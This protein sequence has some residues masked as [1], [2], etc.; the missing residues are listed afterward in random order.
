MIYK[1]V[2]LRPTGPHL[3]PTGLDADYRNWGSYFIAKIRTKKLPEAWAEE[4]DASA[5]EWNAGGHVS[6]TLSEK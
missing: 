5:E 2:V 3:D 6:E 4:P 1:K